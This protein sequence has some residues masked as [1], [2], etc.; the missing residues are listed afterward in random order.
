MWLFHKVHGA[1]GGHQQ[2]VR[3]PPQKVDGSSHF[4][5]FFSVA[6][7]WGGGFICEARDHAKSTHD[8]RD[9]MKKKLI[10]LVTKEEKKAFNATAERSS[11]I[12]TVVFDTR[13]TL[14][15]LYW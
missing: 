1:V 8:A 4:F 12:C 3:Q 2:N 9:V 5:L 6:R 13:F 15:H 10:I 11:A 14:Q 7:T